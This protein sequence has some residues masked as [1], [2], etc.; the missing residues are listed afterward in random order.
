VKQQCCR[1]G[2]SGRPG[3]S[4]RRTADHPHYAYRARRL[5][6]SRDWRVLWALRLGFEIANVTVPTRRT[7]H[8]SASG[9]LPSG[10]IMCSIH[11]AGPIAVTLIVS[12]L[13]VPVTFTF[14]PANS[15]GFFWSLS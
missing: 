11:F 8:S 9:V 12:P 7:F 5:F 13:S 14:W 10:S 1:S 3:V 2:P 6:F 15:A 4:L